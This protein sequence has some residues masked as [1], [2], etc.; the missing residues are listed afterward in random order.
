M[1]DHGSILE[2]IINNFYAPFIFVNSILP[3]EIKDFGLA[4]KNFAFFNIYF[5][6]AVILNYIKNLDQTSPDLVEAL[7][8]LKVALSTQLNIFYLFYLLRLILFWFPNFNPYLPPLYM[9]VA[10]TEP[11]LT[12]LDKVLPSLF[13]LNLSF[14]TVTVILTLSIK[15]LDN[16]NF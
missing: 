12:F 7:R 6:K 11:A 13:G 8:F 3:H 14:F 16:L 1:G 10:V 9:I 15:I 4:I 5:T 2:T